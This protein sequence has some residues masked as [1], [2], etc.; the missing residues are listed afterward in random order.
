LGGGKKKKKNNG[1]VFS[2]S[3]KTVSEVCREAGNELRVRRLSIHR[4]KKRKQ[5]ISRSTTIGLEDEFRD[6][7]S[8]N[9]GG[10]FC[11]AEKWYYGITLYLSAR[12]K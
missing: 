4:S 12:K 3:G 2:F 9:H 8:E 11:I 5:L 7:S 6:L 1:R 10:G